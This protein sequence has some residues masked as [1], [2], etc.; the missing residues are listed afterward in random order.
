MSGP[1]D[2]RGVNTRALSELFD[3]TTARRDAFRDTITVS[4]LEVYNEDIRDLLV[5]GGGEK[6]VIC[7]MLPSTVVIYNMCATRLE[8]LAV[9]DRNRASASTNLNEHSS[10]VRTAHCTS[11]V[12][13]VIICMCF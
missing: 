5:D 1:D 9:A 2:N 4:I 8:V 12:F 6:Y 7:C 10:R 3:K 11:S 13:L